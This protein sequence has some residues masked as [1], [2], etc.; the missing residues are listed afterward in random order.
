MPLESAT[1]PGGNRGPEDRS[2]NNSS[3]KLDT[4]AE[5]CKSSQ[6]DPDSLAVVKPIPWDADNDVVLFPPH[7]GVALYI[8]QFNEVC[9][10]QPHY[11]D[12]EEDQFVTVPLDRVEAFVR[13]VVRVARGG[14]ARD[15][16]ITGPK[17]SE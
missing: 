4:L 3:Q 7:R 14:V 16:A 5:P 2:H 6:A 8:N 13:A 12:S 11:I 10:R 17:P 1:A 9:I 15:P